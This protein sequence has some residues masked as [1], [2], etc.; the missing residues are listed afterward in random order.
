MKAARPGALPPARSSAARA[1]KEATAAAQG[2]A[3]AV[4]FP[5]AA[6]SDAGSA[7]AAPAPAPSRASL[8]ASPRPLDGEKMAHLAKIQLKSQQRTAAERHA[9]LGDGRTAVASPGRASRA[10]RAAAAPRDVATDEPRRRR[11]ATASLPRRRRGAIA[12]S[13]RTIENRRSPD[14]A[15]PR[16]GP[17]T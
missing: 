7:A 17:A 13:L 5:D 10:I 15:S 3:A 12:P 6:A 9:R 11:G 4:A 14:V 16:G 1:A 8:L 2:S